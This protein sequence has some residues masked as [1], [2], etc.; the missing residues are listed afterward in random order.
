LTG[1]DS[2]CN[3]EISAEVAS[4][5]ADDPSVVAVIGTSCSVA[6][7]TAAPIISE[8]GLVMVSP[9]TTRP[10]LTDPRMHQP[11]YLRVVPNDKFQA[12]VVGALA[13]EELGIQ[14][15]A[16]LYEDNSYSKVMQNLFAETFKELGGEITIQAEV[17]PDEAQV[18]TT[19]ASVARTK[20]ELIFYPVS[21]ES[22]G[23]VTRLARETPGLEE[24]IL[25]AAGDMFVPEL[26]EIAGP[27]AEGLYL[28]TF[29][30]SAVSEFYQDFVGRYEEMYGEPPLSFSHAYAFDAVMMIFDAIERVA[31]QTD[32][33]AL[34]IGRGALREALFATRDFKGLTDVLALWRLRQRQ[35][36]GVS[37]CVLRAK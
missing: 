1:E 34:H 15:A 25:V 7:A 4:W 19:L 11:G 2:N 17:Q 35:G 3:P 8:A 28:S 16:T 20:P 9:S 32:D 23:L 14:R 18:R 24:V 12:R 33:G 37:D 6:A 10:L 22:G 29:D 30:L 26:L 36:G 5:I 27:A 21:L 31:V 13:R